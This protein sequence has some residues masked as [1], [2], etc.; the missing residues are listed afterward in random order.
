MTASRCLARFCAAVLAS[1]ALLGSAEADTVDD[2][3]WDALRPPITA[4]DNPFE[5]LTPDQVDAMREIA[6]ARL[7]QARGLRP[8]A[9]SAARQAAQAAAL[10]AQG[11]DV[12]ALLHRRDT[13]IA[14]R[15]A[16]A[17]APVD[18]LAGRTVRLHGYLVPASADGARV[19]D[20]LFVQGA[21]ACSHALPPPNQVI[22]LPAHAL[23]SI[24]HPVP[25]PLVLSGRIGI[26]VRSSR[27]RLVDG[28]LEVRS[29]YVLDD[30]AIDAARTS[31]LR[32]QAGS[33]MK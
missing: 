22:R 23:D 17:Q 32:P 14:Q 2:L 10:A 16:A 7:M 8:T 15:S 29:V 26:Q 27:L 33:A 1:V 19:T 18:A 28:E 5:R 21:N 20:F 9:E 12:E 25:E 24:E 31:A 6:V 13:L 11:L 30:V 4:E 3:D